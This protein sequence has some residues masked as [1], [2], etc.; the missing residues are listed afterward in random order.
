M[1]KEKREKAVAIKY[2]KEEVAPEII[3]KGKGSIARKIIEAA[4]EHNIP[5]WEDESLVN[6]LMKLD[7]G[8]FIP[9]KLYKAVAE[10]LA[11]VYKMEKKSKKV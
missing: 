1:D 5:I 7:I 9:T 4:K 6:L 3:A 11:F 2:K 10:I 8:E